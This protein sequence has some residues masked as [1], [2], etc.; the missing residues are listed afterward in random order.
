MIAQFAKNENDAQIAKILV[1]GHNILNLYEYYL[2][3]ME[4]FKAKEAFKES[5]SCAL[6][7]VKFKQPDD[8]SVRQ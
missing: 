4:L 6:L 7:A 8:S 3:A 1:A 5:N 2:H